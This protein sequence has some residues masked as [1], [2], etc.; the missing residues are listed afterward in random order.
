LCGAHQLTA[1]TGAALVWPR[2]AAPRSGAGPGI[3]VGRTDPRLVEDQDRD[4]ETNHGVAH[5][6]DIGK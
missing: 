6:E 4:T 1:I 5:L 2:A 3:R